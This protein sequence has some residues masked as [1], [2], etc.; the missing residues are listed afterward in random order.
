VEVALVVFLM[1][2]VVVQVVALVEMVALIVAGRLAQQDKEILVEI[3]SHKA[4]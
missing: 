1:Q 3:T 2:V 4:V